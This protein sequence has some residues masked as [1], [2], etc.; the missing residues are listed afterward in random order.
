MPLGHLRD[1]AGGPSSTAFLGADFGL[2]TFREQVSSQRERMR[3]AP[4][5]QLPVQRARRSTVAHGA[6]M[7]RARSHCETAQKTRLA[8]LVSD[9]R[10]ANIPPDAG[11]VRPVGDHDSLGVLRVR[12][13]YDRVQLVHGGCD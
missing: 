1:P 13:R 5:I 8:G 10:Q 11:G 4:E 6:L 7:H 3:V 12:N 9:Q 2:V